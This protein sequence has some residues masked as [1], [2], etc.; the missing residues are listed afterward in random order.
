MMAWTS[1]ALTSSESPFKISVS[2]TEAWRLW[3]LSKDIGVWYWVLGVGDAWG[4]GLA[5]A[6]ET[7]IP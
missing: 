6:V 1:P 7:P 2:S 5:V 3:M 4:A